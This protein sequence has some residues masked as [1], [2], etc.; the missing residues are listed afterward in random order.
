VSRIVETRTLPPRAAKPEELTMGISETR[1]WSDIEA[2]ENRHHRS[3][4]PKPRSVCV[5]EALAAVEVVDS[6]RSGME[7]RLRE[8]AGRLAALTAEAPQ[9]VGL[10]DVSNKRWNEVAG[11]RIV[12]ATV[13]GE[14]AQVRD[15]GV[16]RIEADIAAWW[17]R[18]RQAAV[19]AVA[20]AQAMP[21]DE[22]AEAAWRQWSARCSREIDRMHGEYTERGCW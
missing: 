16:D 17:Q 1:F 22:Q 13:R 9:L 10:L 20:A 21:A 14:M 18:E 4:P 6:E 8:A 7:S 2:A 5:Q 15:R 11:G 3:Q 19:D 12:S